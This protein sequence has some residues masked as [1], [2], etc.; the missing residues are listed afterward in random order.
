MS[1][2]PVSADSDTILALIAAQPATSLLDLRLDPTPL[3]YTARRAYQMFQERTAA[4]RLSKTYGTSRLDRV[5]LCVCGPEKVGKTTLVKALGGVVNQP[6]DSRTIGIDIV[7]LTLGAAVFSVWDFAGQTEFYV[8]HELLLA[9]HGVAAIGVAA[10]YMVVV[11]LAQPATERE[12]M[13]LYWLRFI[14]SRTASQPGPRPQVVLVVT[15]AD[16][17]GSDVTLA[18][19][20]SF[21]SKWANFQLCEA[22]AVFDSKLQQHLQL[23]DRPV[24]LNLSRSWRGYQLSDLPTTLQALHTKVVNASADVPTCCSALLDLMPQLRQQACL[25]SISEVFERA[26]KYQPTGILAQL[27]SFVGW[28]RAKA[29][30]VAAEVKVQ[31]DI[32]SYLAAMGEIVWFPQKPGLANTVVLN[33]RWLTVD[34]LGSLLAPEMIRQTTNTS[35]AAVAVI[36]P[37]GEVLWRRVANLIEPMLRQANVTDLDASVNNVINILFHLDLCF[38]RDGRLVRRAEKLEAPVAVVEPLVDKSLVPLVLPCCLQSS[39]PDGLW[40]P[41][42]PDAM[43]YLGRRVLCC[44][45][46]D[47]LSAGVFPRLQ[48][49][50]HRLLAQ[51]HPPRLWYNGLF[52]ICASEVECLV[53]LTEKGRAVD[54]WVRTPRSPSAHRDCFLAAEKVLGFL[55]EIGDGLLDVDLAHPAS[56]VQGTYFKYTFILIYIYMGVCVKYSRSV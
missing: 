27:K 31:R 19:D 15:H 40:Q 42:K 54:V 56:P 20:G 33:P 28:S 18:K 6:P 13:L 29:V 9:G 14:A 52:G 55:N 36:G 1:G 34:L 35:T 49:M 4:V 45:N 7:P 50:M 48:T 37:D 25:A 53:T 2:N 23:H 17:A 43:H 5:R 39:Q 12:A 11:S 16:A 32:L 38:A 26:A 47:M 21:I 10:I 30:L 44:Q 3:T 46:W 51:S 22:K 8:T 41:A 24:V